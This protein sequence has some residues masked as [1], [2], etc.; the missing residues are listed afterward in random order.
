MVS[1]V[2]NQTVEILRLLKK[3]IC[4]LRRNMYFQEGVKT[5]KSFK[6]IKKDYYKRITMQ[7]RSSRGQS[8]QHRF[9]IS[10]ATRMS[11]TVRL[12][13]ESFREREVSWAKFFLWSSIVVALML[14]QREFK[15][16]SLFSVDSPLFLNRRTVSFVPK[17]ILLCRRC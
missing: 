15:V 1:F 11:R 16:S 17:S 5:R 14:F 12:V 4:K 6:M 3:I 13:L 10:A 8:N 7:R 2:L 9:P